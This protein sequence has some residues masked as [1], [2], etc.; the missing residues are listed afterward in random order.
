MKLGKVRALVCAVLCG[1]A[2][3]PQAATLHSQG[4]DQVTGSNMSSFVIA[5]SFSLVG[6]YALTGLRFWGLLA[7]QADYSGS[8][9]WAI[10]GNG[11][12]APGGLLFSGTQAVAGSAT[13]GTVLG[14]LSEYEFDVALN[15]QL[16]AGDYWLALHNGPLGN[17]DYTDMYWESSSSGGGDFGHFDDLTDQPD[18][19][20]LSTD[21]EHAFALFGDRVG[22]PKPVPLPAS[23]WL[24]LAGLGAAGVAGRRYR[25]ASL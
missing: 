11:G 22:D 15:L 18:L 13:G 14:F 25:S 19:G 21:L 2:A 12:G 23:G 20:W 24:L 5:E 7:S 6:N 10:H 8:V 3:A 1:L 16:G 9:Y 4:P 17:A